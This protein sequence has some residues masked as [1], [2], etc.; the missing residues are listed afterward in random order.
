MDRQQPSRGVYNY[1]DFVALCQSTKGETTEITGSAMKQLR[2]RLLKLKVPER[3]V[4]QSLRAFFA[5]RRGFINE[6]LVC[7]APLEPL[8]N[9]QVELA[10]HTSPVADHDRDSIDYNHNGAGNDQDHAANDIMVDD[11]G[12]AQG[13]VANNPMALASVADHGGAAGNNQ[14]AAPVSNRREAAGHGRIQPAIGRRQG[15]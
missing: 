1:P 5:T 7:A 14:V 4:P 8:E 11:A 3:D 12:Q 9:R 13:A 15:A 2:K 10:A 6:K